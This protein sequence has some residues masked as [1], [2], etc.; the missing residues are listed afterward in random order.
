MSKKV[1]LISMELIF[2][3]PT[4]IL[5]KFLIRWA[6]RS[7]FEVWPIN[8]LLTSVEFRESSISLYIFFIRYRKSS[9]D[10]PNKTYKV[11]T[12]VLTRYGLGVIY[13]YSGVLSGSN[14]YDQQ[15]VM[16]VSYTF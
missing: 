6:F 1:E 16:F 8:L 2:K 9:T 10:V 12:Q 7:L 14:P 15:K 4:T 11:L 13:F 3:W 5:L